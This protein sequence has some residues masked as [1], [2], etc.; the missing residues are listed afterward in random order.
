[1]R[2]GIWQ[3]I[4]NTKILKQ[5]VRIAEREIGVHHM[6]D[7]PWYITRFLAEKTNYILHFP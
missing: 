6:I 5:K 2:G 7:P 3:S 4:Q 1:M